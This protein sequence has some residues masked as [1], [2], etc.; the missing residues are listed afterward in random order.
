MIDPDIRNS[1]WTK[2]Q[3]RMAWSY[4]NYGCYLGLNNNHKLKKYIHDVFID[5]SDLRYKNK[6]GTV[7]LGN[8]FNY[9]F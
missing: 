1:E 5:V 6:T 2:N 9:F 4:S 3:R 8:Q 7:F